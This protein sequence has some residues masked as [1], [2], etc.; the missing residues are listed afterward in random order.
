MAQ[1]HFAIY[2]N[3]CLKCSHLVDTA[4]KAYNVCHYSKGNIACPAS[5]VKIVVVGKAI[6][7]AEKVKQARSE[8]NIGAEARILTQVAL[9]SSA[10]QERFYSELER[11]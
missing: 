10:F 2:S 4:V 3:N 1:E 11:R 8:R 6:S 9:M 7:L 5:E